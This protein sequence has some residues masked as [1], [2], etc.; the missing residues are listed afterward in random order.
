MHDRLRASGRTRSPPPA[1]PNVRRGEEPSSG[2]AVLSAAAAA[3]E[4]PHGLIPPGSS[5]VPSTPGP[6]PPPA[7]GT[8][9]RACG[10]SSPRG[11]PRA[12]GTCLREARCVQGGEA[13][14]A[15]L[16]WRGDSSGSSERACGAGNGAA[17]A[18]RARLGWPFLTDC[19]ERPELVQPEEGAEGPPG[20]RLAA[21]AEGEVGGVALVPLAAGPPDAG[22]WA[23][24]SEGGWGWW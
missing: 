6:R 10:P 2:F 17:L 8:R 19:N 11:R 1:H 13:S 18:L 15:R 3:N 24:E 12:P 14:A 20:E 23:G 7:R 16:G 4:Q 9:S 5:R 22:G 21:A